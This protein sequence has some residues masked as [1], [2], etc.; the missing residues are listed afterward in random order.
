MR[1]VAQ[2]TIASLLLAA[3]ACGAASATVVTDPAND[4][5][6]SFGGAHSGDIDVLSTS[7]TFNGTSFQLGGT[8]NGSIGTLPTSLYVFG[9]NRGASTANFAAIGLSNVIFDA[10]ITLT[11]TGVLGGRDLVANAALNLAGATAT[12]SG[13][14]LLI[15]VP[16]S[17]LPS[18]GFSA[19]GYQF[20][21]WPRDT[22]VA[23]N[24]AIS[25]FAP[26]TS[27]FLASQVPEPWT[28]ALLLTGLVGLALS[29][30]AASV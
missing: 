27:D 26:N 4:F 21:L 6:P 15:N 23:G 19:L 11:G 28:A 16:L 5:I 22:S 10:V 12:I 24:A 7:A 1:K 9:V 14:S 30:R 3:G 13:T 8:M 29:R 20:N 17:D 25:D 18:Q 2:W